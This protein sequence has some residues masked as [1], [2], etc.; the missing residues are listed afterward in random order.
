MYS[1]SAA[2]PELFSPG[3]SF[4]AKFGGFVSV[5]P[6]PWSLEA[7]LQCR[8]SLSILGADTPEPGEEMEMDYPT[9]YS[10]LGQLP[11]DL[12]LLS[13][14]LSRPLLDPSAPSVTPVV[15]IFSLYTLIQP[16]E[17]KLHQIL[18]LR[19]EK[20]I[21]MIKSVRPWN[22]L[23]RGNG[24]SFITSVIYT[25]A[26]QKDKERKYWGKCCSYK[27]SWG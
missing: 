11:W 6:S 5:L 26:G 25:W 21:I 19:K 16:G 20:N 4:H 14:I 18:G 15:L 23:P 1:A 2:T 8:Y 9:F 7:F 24:G 27:S 3:F 13:S 10:R 12:S 17:I 22:N